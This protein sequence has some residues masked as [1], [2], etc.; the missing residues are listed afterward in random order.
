[1]ASGTVVVVVTDTAAPR[2]ATPLSVFAGLASTSAN[3]RPRMAATSSTATPDS[4]TRPRRVRKRL[5][6]AF[7]L[8][9]RP[10][11]PPRDPD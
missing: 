7:T 6:V 5:S 8:S 3:T 4:T 11:R 2:V 1:L 10:R 9:D